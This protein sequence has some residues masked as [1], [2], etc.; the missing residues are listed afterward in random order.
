MD[1]IQHV[2]IA[3]RGK[4]PAG[5]G[6]FK[7]KSEGS[8]EIKRMYVHPDFRN[9]GIASQIISQLENW[10]KNEGFEKCILETGKRQIEAVNFY[11]RMNY[12]I[13]ENYPPYENMENSVCFAKKLV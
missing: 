3:Y 8:A 7:K 1:T 13:I 4:Y 2:I 6:A 11:R 9:R 5:C 12:T 10:A